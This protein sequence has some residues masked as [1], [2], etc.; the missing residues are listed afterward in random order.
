VSSPPIS[1]A[2]EAVAGGLPRHLGLAR[3]HPL[4]ANSFFLWSSAGIGALSGFAFWTLAAR[5]YGSSEIGLAS[6]GLAGW[7]LLFNNVTMGVLSFVGV[8]IISCPCAIGIATPTALMVGV[9]KGAEM[10]ILIRGAQHLEQAQNLTAVV[11]DKT[12][13][14]TKGEPSVTDVVPLGASDPG[15]ILRI[16]ASAERGSEH[17][18]A[19]AVVREAQMR[20][21][22]LSDPGA[23]EARP[24]RGLQAT[25]AGRQVLLG[26]RTLLQQE[27]I[28]FGPA[29][30]VWERLE[31][32]GKT[33][34]NLVV[35]ILYLFLDPRI[36]YA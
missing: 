17:P 13:T 5:W 36:S 2:R 23:V 6:A 7:S 34:M 1:K 12:G 14:L 21:I 3:R 8:L 24:G 22:P 30:P 9:G 10:G 35:D 16:A 32:Q 25:V 4:F 11:F 15:Q 33:V 19:K 18:L 27:K 29:E 20:R 31:S 26:N 28:P